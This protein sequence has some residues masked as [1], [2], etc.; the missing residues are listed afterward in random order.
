MLILAICLAGL[1]TYGIILLTY[2]IFHDQ[3]YV[4]IPLPIFASFV[5]YLLVEL[6]IQ[7]FKGLI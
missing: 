5:L 1:V 6:I 7:M 3:L 4:L 2:V